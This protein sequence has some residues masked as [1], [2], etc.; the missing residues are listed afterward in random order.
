MARSESIR[1][2]ERGPFDCPDCR[3]ETDGELQ[4]VVVRTTFLGIPLGAVG[5][6][7][8]RVRCR[9]C[10]GD[11]PPAAFERRPPAA[12]P[13]R[14]R[15]RPPAD[16]AP[17]AAMPR[18]ELDAAARPLPSASADAYAFGDR[19]LG[20]WD[21][22]WYPGT[23]GARDPRGIKVVFDDGDEGIF[24]PERV[25]PLD[26]R[27]GERVYARWQGGT[28]YFPGRIESIE[29]DD[30][31]IRYD[32]GR[33]EKTTIRVVRV[34]RGDL[35]HPWRRGD[36]V[37]AFWPPSKLLYFPGV[38]RNISE[39]IFCE[40]AFDDGDRGV[41]TPDQLFPIDLREGD[42]IFFRSGQG[43]EAADLEE[44]QGER[45]TLRALNTR[46]V[47][48]ANLRTIAIMHPNVADE[49]RRQQRGQS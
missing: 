12:A 4:E 24:G 9:R 28:N 42:L 6:P 19:V 13:S 11:F 22:F 3:T 46:Q 26:I 27:A 32:D 5:E 23:I 10:G 37:F 48:K 45:L 49:F 34:L 30:I 36:R 14:P 31:R 2:L 15:L 21:Y 20:Q 18:R 39:E 41:A 43:F 35:D 1:I 16:A 38:I 8:R 7:T 33:S 44:I 47:H 17:I 29:G 25:M 40:I